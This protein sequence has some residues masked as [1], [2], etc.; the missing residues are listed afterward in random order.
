MLVDG[1]G[2][3]SYGG[4]SRSRLDPG[5][6]V[7]APYLWGRRIRSLDVIAST[8]GHEDHIG[9]LPALVDAFHPREIWTG[10]TPES[11]GWS[12]LREAAERS[13]ARIVPMH[14]GDTLRFG[15]ADLAVLAPVM[16]YAPA[17]TPGNNDSLVLQISYGQRSFLL[18]G[19][20]EKR[21]EYEMLAAEA[22]RRA[23]VLKVAHHGSRTSTTQPF[24]D[25]VRPSFSIISAGF[26]NSYR[27]PSPDVVERISQ[28]GSMTYETDQDGLVSIRT[29]GRRLYVQTNSEL[30]GL[31]YLPAFGW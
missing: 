31:S 26:E 25:A 9:G 24:L 27:N 3:P 5:E 29:D 10:A 14:G 22:V 16:D 28:S 6:D 17:A 21:I 12:K 1:G 7:V 11:S 20:V 23:D 8:H 2:F 18:T 4:Q 15:G 13:H 19:D 30:H